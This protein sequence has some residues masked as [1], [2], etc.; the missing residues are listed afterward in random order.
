MRFTGLLAA[1][2][3]LGLALG[4]CGRNRQEEQVAQHAAKVL[5]VPADSLRV[6]TE[7]ELTGGFHDF[8]LATA[9]DGKSLVVVAPK[10]GEMFDARTPDAFDRVSRGEHATERLSQLGA[11]RV[12]SWFAALGG[13][14]CP[15]PPV[16]QAHFVEVS[17]QQD[18]NV[19]LSYAALH[20]IC[21]INLRADGSLASARTA[22]AL[23][24]SAAAPARWQTSVSKPVTQ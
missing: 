2:L 8:F 5:K 13:G 14:V 9:Q 23:G 16:D 6:T 10:K 7:S 12:A 11:E 22:D 24:P 20:R 1:A 4:A 21:V 15:L 19:Q 3:V 17:R 18:G